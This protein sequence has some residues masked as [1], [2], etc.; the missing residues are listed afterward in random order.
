MNYGLPVYSATNVSVHK[1]NT[2]IEPNDSVSA[3]SLLNGSEDS[4]YLSYGTLPFESFWG[5]QYIS[6]A[7]CSLLS[8]NGYSLMGIFPVGLNSMMPW[9]PCTNSPTYTSSYSAGLLSIWLS[10]SFNS[11]TGNIVL[12]DLK[13]ASYGV[14]GYWDTRLVNA[15]MSVVLYFTL[16]LSTNSSNNA[17]VASLLP[18]S[19]IQL[20]S[21]LRYAG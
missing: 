21:L 2:N 7:P 10:L 12:F 17:F 9:L 8:F 16:Y 19:S 6:N 4:I 20:S 18:F 11:V 15:V 13:I 5:I 14:I 1:S 3:P